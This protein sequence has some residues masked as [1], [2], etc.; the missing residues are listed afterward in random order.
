MSVLKHL[1]QAAEHLRKA[2]ESSG[3]GTGM[4]IQAIIDD[5]DDLIQRTERIERESDDE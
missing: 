4:M 5:L 2:R 1:R 3:I